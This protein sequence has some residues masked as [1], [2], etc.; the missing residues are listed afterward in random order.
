MAT[1]V[2]WFNVMSYDIYGSWDS[3]A[4]ANADMPYIQN[5]MSNIFAL[6][7]PREKLVFGLAAYGRST[8]LASPHC[9]TAGCQVW[10]AG[11]GG[12]HGEAGNLPYFEI[13]QDYVETGDYDELNF[14]PVTKS[15][16]LITGGYQY[17]TS[18][19]NA[20]T[21]K[22]KKNYAY[23][24]CLRGVMWWAVDLIIAPID[25][26]F[27]T[28]SPTKSLVPSVKPSSQPSSE[29]S[30]SLEP[31]V[32]LSEAP[33]S[34]PSKSTEPSQYPSESFHPSKSLEP[35][36]SASPTNG[37][38]T[39][40][41]PF[42]YNGLIVAIPGCY[43]F[44]YCTENVPSQVLFCPA[45]TLFDESLNTCNWAPYVTC[46]C[47]MPTPRP[48]EV[49]SS[50]PSI[51]LEPSSKPSLQPS[52]EPS[53]SL[54]PSYEGQTRSP[55][56]RATPRPTTKISVCENCPPTGW[57]FVSSSGCTGFFHCLEG[58]LASYQMCPPGTMFDS[59]GMF[60]D[61]TSRVTCNCYV[62]PQPNPPPPPP[63]S[64]PPPGPPPPLTP[65]PTPRPTPVGGFPWYPDW[66][67]TNECVNDGNDPL[68]I[69]EYLADTKWE[70]CKN[71][72]WW[73]EAECL[74][75]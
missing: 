73:R 67:Y 75:S 16:E 18:F 31:S 24:Q 45:G 70:C 5:T 37:C 72:Y 34:G 32:K 28:Q 57:H 52:S 68:W 30:I 56:I 33:S 63:G 71:N 44:F 54:T 53:L 35:S 21:L 50:E 40:C 26:D 11:L 27:P 23:D 2:S 55:T 46:S 58:E 64:P 17:F 12:C 66:D 59:N 13:M 7:I 41:P 9:H 60:C 42:S 4:G 15:M 36:L 48:T 51:S 22:I 61:Y 14:N 20:L 69:S 25:F 19:D 8:R 65:L 38:G 43:G 29:P 10:G 3:T 47:A 74:A 6:D 39:A 1:H 62:D 49:P